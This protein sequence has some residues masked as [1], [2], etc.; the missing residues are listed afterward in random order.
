MHPAFAKERVADELKTCQAPTLIMWAEDNQFHSWHRFKPLA[1]KLR[2]RLGNSGYC[3][4]RTKRE[5]DPAWSEMARSREI[6]RFL[7]RVDPVP[8]AQ[9]VANRPERAAMA[10]DGSHITQ[11]DGVV[12]RSNV[13]AEM[14]SESDPAV[15]ACAELVR[16]ER[17]G[18]LSSLIRGLATTGGS[19]HASAMRFARSLPRLDDATITPANLEALGL[20]S[21]AARNAAE[22]LQ[23]RVAGSPRYF[24]GRTVLVPGNVCALG[25]LQSCDVANDTAVVSIRHDARRLLEERAVPWQALMLLN[26]R[27]TLP[28]TARADGS[29]VL[30][31]EDG[32]WADFASPLLRAELARVAL[33]LDT[34]FANDVAQAL[35]DHNC[36]SALDKA[37][38]AAIIALRDCLDVTSFARRSFERGRDRERYAKDDVAKMA[39]HGEGHCRTCSSCLAPFLWAF[40]ELLAV[41]PH[42][43]MDAGARHQWLQYETRPSMRSFSCDLY[44][45]EDVYLS[46]GTRGSMLVQ[47]VE[48]AYQGPES[49]FPR[50][51]P[52]DLSGRMVRSAPLEPTDLA[53]SLLCTQR[54]PALGRT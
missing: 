54:T 27:H 14:L 35:Q 39:A 33:A 5:A 48:V 18:E 20:W 22:A 34:I 50:D 24:V 32:M 28:S 8:E 30:R 19:V 16:A 41:D 52:L 42:Y 17:A 13:T 2:Q 4:Y 44:R 23:E 40:A 49:F 26:Q 47:A 31:L 7:T 53:L 6:V 21:R 1:A 36:D 38:G 3:E 45:D 12:F 10:T 29:V 43:C 15:E 37:R 25:V 46:G 51:A 11:S 9:A